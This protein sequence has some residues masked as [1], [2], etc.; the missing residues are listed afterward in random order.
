VLLAQGNTWVE[1]V[2]NDSSDVDAAVV[3]VK[4]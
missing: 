3:T 2:P 1:L 4:E